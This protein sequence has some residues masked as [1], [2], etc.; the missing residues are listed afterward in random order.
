MK[1]L[2][3]SD[4][5]LGAI[6]SQ[7]NTTVEKIMAANKGVIHDKNKIFVGQ[8]IEIPDQDEVI[9]FN[10]FPP[11]V[12]VGGN[13]SVEWHVKNLPTVN[14]INV[15][16]MLEPKGVKTI[17]AQDSPGPMSFKLHLQKEH[18]R[19]VQVIEKQF[20]M[21]PLLSTTTNTCQA[22]NLPSDKQKNPD[23]SFEDKKPEKELSVFDK[24]TNGNRHY[25]DLSNTLE[26]VQKDSFDSISI[27]YIAPDAPEKLT[28]TKN[29][30]HYET[31]A[32]TPRAGGQ[33]Y[34]FKAKYYPEDGLYSIKPG[35]I[36]K[37]LFTYYAKPTTYTIT[38]LQQNITI[39][40][41]NPDQ[42]KFVLK[43]P[44]FRGLKLGAQMS[45]ST[46]QTQNDQLKETK[47]EKSYTLTAEET[48][49]TQS[50]SIDI[51]K[52]Y[53]AYTAELKSAELYAYASSQSLT[54]TAK[55][56]QDP[57]KI[58]LFDGISLER[59]AALVNI[60]ALDVILGV[61][62]LVSRFTK[63][64]KNFKD[65]VPKIGWYID[66]D[67]KVLEGI[68]ELSWGW[69]ETS[70]YRVYYYLGLGVNLNI[71]EIMLEIGFGVSVA[72][73]GGQ[74][75]IQF[76]GG[77]SL[78]LAQFET[79]APDAE[80]LKLG[81]IKGILE[82]GGYVRCNAGD[83]L[84]IEGGIKSS[85][86]IA[87]QTNINF[88]SGLELNGQIVWDGLIVALKAQTFFGWQRQ[89]NINLMDPST[90]GEFKFPSDK[91][92]AAQDDIYSR[93]EISDIVEDVITKGWDIRVFEKQYVT[94]DYVFWE[95]LEL[96]NVKMNSRDV[97]DIISDKI[98][99]NK[100]QLMLDT[101]TINGLAHS[102]RK[103]CEILG[104]R[105]GRDFLYRSQLED[106]LASNS[107]KKVIQEA[108]DPAKVYMDKLKKGGHS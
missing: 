34:E 1:Y 35:H 96:V 53:S 54:T 23:V 6:A 21:N 66:F 38:D 60:D 7:H 41:Y 52:K 42:W 94:I 22:K 9:S 97:A 85:I 90:M 84:V 65:Y 61:I 58:S 93:L 91:S 26:I 83:L 12:E 50:Q 108:T 27:H 19:T 69:R 13:I 76:K 99:T 88:N 32:G 36:L 18:I 46:K 10:V 40:A 87:S 30:Q 82:A 44:P 14:I 78:N 15:G 51:S 55:F 73:I 48:K 4:D 86:T 64:I 43:L 79:I 59:N 39:K 95:K 17:K 105:F 37:S 77:V 106:Y 2:V 80:N 102:V 28:V 104:K 89:K 75:C 98:W 62:S 25:C 67:V 74:V 3:K 45:N 107:F 20:W 103:E 68:L 57:N 5:T 81:E 33:L 47:V 92:R 100:D 71:F 8:S 16:Y 49:W 11:T 70:T 63:A 31:I 24:E 101:K 56:T 29:G 72:N